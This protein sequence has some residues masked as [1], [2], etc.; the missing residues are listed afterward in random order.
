MNSHGSTFAA[1]S[2]DG[3]ASV[4]ALDTGVALHRINARTPIRSL[5]WSTGSEGFI[6]GC[7]NGVLVS[8]LLE[9]VLPPFCC[10]RVLGVNSCDIDVHQDR[11]FP[12][13]F[14][15]NMLHITIR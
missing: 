12:C 11:V 2:L 14:R 4:W 9:E 8:V 3:T 1:G 10:Y 7:E 15:A 6:F 13:P 5:V